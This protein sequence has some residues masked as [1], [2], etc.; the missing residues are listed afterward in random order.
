MLILHP[1]RAFAAATLWEPLVYC[2]YYFCCCNR[3]LFA[4]LRVYT[5]SQ[6]SVD[7]SKFSGFFRSRRKAATR[8][9]AFSECF[10]AVY[11][12]ANYKTVHTVNFFPP[13]VYNSVFGEKTNVGLLRRILVILKPVPVHSN[14]FFS[15]GISDLNSILINL[16]QCVV[17]VTPV[18]K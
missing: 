18:F 9:N 12:N 10:T 2:C 15:T 5:V 3:L 11:R 17:V 16:Q 6:G 7:F 8:S 1:Y 14:I 4:R 13:R